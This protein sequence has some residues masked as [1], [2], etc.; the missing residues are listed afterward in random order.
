MSQDG[1]KTG[2][3]LGAVN[4]GAVAAD[5]CVTAASSHLGVDDLSSQPPVETYWLVRETDSQV[6]HNC[7]ATTHENHVLLDDINI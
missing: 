6:N 3:W 4:S 1:E 7:D 2:A 5:S